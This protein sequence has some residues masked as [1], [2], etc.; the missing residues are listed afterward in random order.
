MGRLKLLISA[1]EVADF[2]LLERESVPSLLNQLL[3]GL[4]LRRSVF[5]L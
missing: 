2:L 5:S 4:Y 1:L 3:K